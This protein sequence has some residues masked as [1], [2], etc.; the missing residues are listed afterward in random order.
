[1]RPKSW[2]RRSARVWSTCMTRTSCTETSNRR[3]SP[4]SQPS[5]APCGPS[6]LASRR[7]P[8]LC[9]HFAEHSPCFSW[10]RLWRQGILLHLHRLLLLNI[11]WY[12]SAIGGRF[13]SFTPLPR[14]RH[15]W[16]EDWHTLWHTWLRGP[17]G[18]VFH[19]TVHGCFSLLSWML[20]V[21]GVG[22]HSI[23]VWCR[24]VEPGCHHL[25][26]GL[27][28]P[29]FPS[30]HGQR[31]CQEGQDSRLQL[32]SALLGWEFRRMQGFHQKGREPHSYSILFPHN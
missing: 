28:L 17:W 20:C 24:C 10:G 7:Y 3:S 12:Y 11:F 15:P 6:S 31:L 14:G 1:M 25:H 26:H 2:L 32:P 9:G 4:N 22:A 16:A 23:L 13:R 19:Y 5:I 18:I 21:V 29:T 30:R 8:N 27:W